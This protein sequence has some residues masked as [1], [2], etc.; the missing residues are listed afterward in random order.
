[1]RRRALLWVSMVTLGLLWGLGSVALAATFTVNTVD[2]L[3]DGSCDAAHCSL[4]EAIAA[5][6]AA[7]G[8]DLIGFDIPGAASHTIQPGYAFPAITDPATID[9]TTQPG[10]AGSPIVEIDGTNAG[11]NTNG[12]HITSGESVIH[13]LVIN[14]FDGAAIQIEGGGSNTVV[15]SFI[16]TNSDGTDFAEGIHKLAQPGIAIVDSPANVIGGTNANQRNLL[17]GGPAL[18]IS[19]AASEDNTIQGNY[20]G[21]DVDGARWLHA[22]EHPVASGGIHIDGAPG[23][24]IGGDVSG[25]GN[26][27]AE[28]LMLGRIVNLRI[29]GVAADGNI[30]QGNR[31]GTDVTGSDDLA[32]VTTIGLL[33]DGA[34]N[35][36]I[37]GTTITASNLF[38]GVNAGVSIEGPLAAHTVV[39]GNHFGTKLGGTEF[40]D[41]SPTGVGIQIVD[42]PSTMIG[43]GAPGTGNVIA[44]RVQGITI[45]GANAVDTFIQRN[46]IGTDIT[47]TVGIGNSLG[48]WILQDASDVTI[49]GPDADHRNI[50]SDNGTGIHADRSKDLHLENNYIG[51]DMTGE[52]PLGNGRAALLFSPDRVWILRNVV[53]ANS[54]GIQLGGGNCTNGESFV[55]GNFFG[56]NPTGEQVVGSGS[57]LPGLSLLQ[58]QNVLV[59]GTGNGE[60][61]VFSG[62]NTGLSLLASC[63]GSPSEDVTIEG[64]LIGTDIRGEVA[65]GNQRGIS[66]GEGWTGVDTVIG[67]IEEDAGNVIS[68]NTD[69]IVVGGSGI[70]IQGN[71]IGSDQGGLAGIGNTGAGIQSIDAENVVIGGPEAGEG[72]VIAASGDNGIFVSHG[73]NIQIEGNLVG[74]GSDGETELPNGAGPSVTGG[75]DISFG[76]DLTATANVVSSNQGSGISTHAAENVVIAD[77]VVG[78]DA[79]GISPRPNTEEGIE[80]AGEDNTIRSNVV[81]ANG[82][83]GVTVGAEGVSAPGPNF[84]FGNWIGTNQAGDPGLGNGGD[85]ILVQNATDTLIGSADLSERN[86]IVGNGGDGIRIISRVAFDTVVAGNLI[87]VVADG[88]P[89]GNLGNGVAVSSS[90][91]ATIGGASEQGNVIAHNHGAG[92]AVFL[93]GTGTPD[94][95]FVSANSIHSNGALGIDLSKVA[96]SPSDGPTANDLGDGD[97]GPN[98]LQNFPA[99]GSVTSDGVS[100]RIVGELSSSAEG[101]FHVEFF[102]NESVGCDPSGFGEGER[103]LGS[104]MVT[105]GVD[106]LG[107]FDV[108]LPVGVTVGA[109][110][111]S[112]ATDAGGSTSE[113]SSCVEVGEAVSGADLS[114]VKSDVAD[115]VVEGGQVS[116]LVEVSNHGPLDAL[117]VVA[118]DVLP[119]GVELMLASPSQGACS[120]A[121]ETVVCEFGDLPAG[122]SVTL[123][124]VVEAPAPG[125][126]S[127]Q[128]SVSSQTSDPDSSNNTAIEETTISDALPSLMVAKTP[129]PVSVPETGEEVTFHVTVTNTSVAADPLTLTGLSDSIWQ[130]LDGDGIEDP[131][132]VT[133]IDPT[134]PSAVLATSC[135]LPQT[136]AGDGGFYT[137]N[138]TLLVEG[139]PWTDPVDMLTAAGVDDENNPATG[140]GSATVDIT[141]VFGRS[142]D[143]E[144]EFLTF[145]LA[146]DRS[147]VTGS[148][149]VVNASGDE[150]VDVLITRLDLMV[151]YRKQERGAEWTDANAVCVA[152]PALPI[153]LVDQVTIGF[154]CALATAV[155]EGAEL[156]VTATLWIDGRDKPFQIRVSK[157][158]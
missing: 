51:T 106:G 53:S 100:T 110:V 143:L 91:P 69:G 28:N 8:H 144:D 155:P 112:T 86:V 83:A 49:G 6:N 151:E 37:G 115:P 29:R 92:V 129:D 117:E 44:W 34:P 147:A 125:T 97:V 79:E 146:S 94:G 78:L 3:D 141:G 108:T 90:N 17:A 66:I 98:G 32:S 18:L 132:E 111:T 11:L 126:L 88:S 36:L 135:V 16:N 43:G 48:I 72:N 47:G 68:G 19:G 57:Q 103:F 77:N 27:I 84:I 96:L 114:V 89:M 70:L 54:G 21:T 22:D 109:T 74:L 55:Q 101:V 113:F 145:Q 85:G 5:A 46:R 153:V 45:S 142:V 33:V 62:N 157:H 73:R 1:M 7:P 149:F 38:S 156:R 116:Y 63:S 9:A 60:G 30:V 41:P 4:R 105:T 104:T 139:N 130:D 81:A 131:G 13:G 93:V 64:N 40:I 134:D 120:E 107:V 138:Y 128:V 75:I 25:A 99:L 133:V 122:E 148:L 158:T 14:R 152:D 118:T 137:C 58:V 95:V 35:T 10:Y 59:G 124:L 71:L 65:L 87:G 123:E 67:G 61:N 150:I 119:G 102:A 42:A 15:A 82:G 121:G 2:D 39:Q 20:I 76:T 26:L 127:N 12:L 56:T 136:L 24:L 154:T 80:A 140:S 23:N 50:I 31:I 52:H